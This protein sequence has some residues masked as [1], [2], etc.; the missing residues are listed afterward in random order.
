[1]YLEQVDGKI[2][3]N[4]PLKQVLSHFNPFE[5]TIPQAVHPF[6]KGLRE[7]VGPPVGRHTSPLVK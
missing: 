7:D 6:K 3:K 2:R 1:M 4:Q 5:Q